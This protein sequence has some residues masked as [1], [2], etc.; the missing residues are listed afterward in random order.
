[1]PTLKKTALVT[2]AENH[3]CLAAVRSLG[4]NKLDVTCYFL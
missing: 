2:N 1:M 3:V 4:K